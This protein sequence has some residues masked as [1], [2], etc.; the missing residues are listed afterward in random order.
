[1]S[2]ARFGAHTDPTFRSEPRPAAEVIRR[3]AEYLK[4]YRWAAVGT[5]LCAVA[6]LGFGMLYPRLTR[7]LIDD[8]VAVG[9]N[10]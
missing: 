7:L 10:G 6:S 9:R 8:V 1:M 2:H 5:I 3:V 4:P